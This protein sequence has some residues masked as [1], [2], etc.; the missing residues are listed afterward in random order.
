MGRRLWNL[1]FNDLVERLRQTNKV[2]AYVYDLL[3]LVEGNFK[4]IE[5][6]SWKLSFTGWKIIALAKIK[7][8]MVKDLLKVNKSIVKVKLS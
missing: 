8:I 2:V 7:F 4:A 6:G 5:V 3:I 1:N